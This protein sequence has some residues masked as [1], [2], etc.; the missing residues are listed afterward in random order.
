MSVPPRIDSDAAPVDVE[1]QPSAAELARMCRS[2]HVRLTDAVT[3]GG[4]TAGRATWWHM[5]ELVHDIAALYANWC[6]ATTDWLLRTHGFA[7][8]AAVFPVSELLPGGPVTVLSP[9]QTALARAVYRATDFPTERSD[10]ERR[11]GAAEAVAALTALWDEVHAA[12]DAAEVLR[13]DAATALV[14]LVH[15]RY[16]PDGLEDCLRHATGLV[17][18]PRMAADLGRP[19]LVRLRAWAE[20][21]SVGHNGAVSIRAEADRWVIV[22]DPCGSCGRQLLT[23]RYRDPWNFRVVAPGHRVGFL[24]DDITVY[25]AHLAVAHTMVPIELT[26]APWP[27]MQCA[28]LAARPCELVLYRDPAT[29]AEPFYAQVGMTRP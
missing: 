17:W 3:D 29:T 14:S 9:E 1:D 12:L 7:A 15:D 11:V 8:A 2:P 13:R 20:K 22:L 28:G 18:R 23:G 21:M 16:G 10:L 24:R 26:G 27:A 4:P 6:T 19:P 5:V 25:Q